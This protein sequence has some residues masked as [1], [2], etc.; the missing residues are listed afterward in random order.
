MTGA[1]PSS[2]V[3]TTPY[4][5]TLSASYTQSLLKGFGRQV[6]EANVIVAKKG[7]IAADYQYQKAIIDLVASTES[8]YWDVVFAQRNLENKQQALTL[9]QKQLKENRIRVEVG[10]LAPIEVTS[11]EASVAQ[12]EQD[13]IAAEAQ[14]DNAKDALIRALYPSS[15]RPAGL[16]LTEAPTLSHL[17][18]D[19]KSA[20]KMA[21][22]RRV[23]LKSARLDPNPSSSW[24]AWPRTV[25]RLS[26]ISTLGTTAVP[27]T[28]IPIPR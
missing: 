14:F 7:A 2:S 28:T 11:A 21:I 6:T 12:R 22:E 24:K 19:E 15:E 8:L 20:E 5:G 3:T 26:W 4:T 16:E 1:T 17:T 10:T 18:T 13:I 25:C 9:A 23:E 27:P